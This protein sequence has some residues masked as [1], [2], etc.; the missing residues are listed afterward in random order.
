MLH[1]DMGKDETLK[2]ATMG[3]ALSETDTD[4]NGRVK[5]KE[6]FTKDYVKIGNC[7][8]LMKQPGYPSLNPPVL[9]EIN[10][11]FMDVA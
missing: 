6:N 2:W 9:L 10:L 8:L 7:N 3:F 4:I 11:S 1:K 5:E